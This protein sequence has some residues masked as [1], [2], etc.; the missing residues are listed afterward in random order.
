MSSSSVYTSV[1]MPTLTI[2]APNSVNDAENGAV[3]SNKKKKQETAKTA[4]VGNKET[5]NL[6]GKK[7]K[8]F[9]YGRFWKHKTDAAFV[10]I[11]VWC[12]FLTILVMTAPG[13]HIVPKLN[14]M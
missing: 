2:A 3:V 12:I 10:F 4:K 9:V 5:L 13:K 8:S 6:N 14:S 1:C 7:K 11:V